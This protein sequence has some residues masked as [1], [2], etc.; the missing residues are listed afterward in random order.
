[1][2]GKIFR[3]CFL[4]GLVVTILCTGLFVVVMASR[5]EREVYQELE[6][7]LVYVQHGLERSGMDYL[8]GLETDQRL[9]WVAED[10][11]VLYDNVADPKTMG[12][13]ADRE[14][15]IQAQQEGT[16]RSKHVSET[17]LEKTLYYAVRLSDGTVLRISCQ[18][19]T[20]GALALDVLQPVVWVLVLAVALSGLLASRTARQ[21]VR[22]INS[23][24]LENPRLDETYEE[25]FPLVSRLK[26]QNRT[27]GQQMETL[28]RRQREFSA[29]AEN[30]N[31]GVL[32]V[33]SRYNVLFGNQSA[34]SLLGAWE[35]PESLRQ[36]NCRREIWEAAGKALAGRHNGTLMDAE[37]RIYEILANPV[38]V[39][40]QVTG[41]V[42]FMMDVTEREERESLR[43][44]FS[45]NVSHELKTPLTAISGFAELMKE[46][47]VEGEKLREFAGDIYKECAR[48]IALIDD[49]MKLSRLDEDSGDLTTELVDL[50]ALA[51]MV[52]KELTPTAEKRS[53][54]I[55]VEGGHQQIQGV[56]RILHEM[57]YN[58]CDNAIKYN[59]DGGRV[60]LRVTGSQEKA[61]LTVEDTGIGIPKGQQDRVFERFYR[62]DKSHSR[63][64][65]GTGLGLSIVKHG[66]QYHNA[67]ITMDSELDV[68]TTIAV[69]FPKQTFL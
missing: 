31:E 68:G 46:G 44:E 5:Y 13:H 41:A 65:G 10:G 43:R 40:G 1:M 28:S 37:S 2:T 62:V 38:A 24:D 49:I 7:E 54:Q 55:Q 6:E 42:V 3:G 9:T 25:I 56:W 23:I 47:M 53:I 45:A 36:D 63:Q 16:G 67:Q 66:A 27:I 30:M 33:D 20:M 32:L 11:T 15:V 21:I 39:S 59:K 69:T 61:T 29:L 26:E 17:L 4:V 57:A 51:K 22:P 14:E 8:T 35:A 48:L 50:Y 34:F 60:V 18:E 64:I 58:L 52:Q 19:T 12:N